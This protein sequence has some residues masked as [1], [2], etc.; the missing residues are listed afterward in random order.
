MATYVDDMPWGESRFN[1]R[2]PH[3]ILRSNINEDSLLYPPLY[4]C[5]K[6]L[7]LNRD[8]LWFIG[9][10]ELHFQPLQRTM[11]RCSSSGNIN[12]GMI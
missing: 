1:H 4:E 11:L 12:N 3:A 10:L 2:V 8:G 5:S 9:Y 7:E 6:P